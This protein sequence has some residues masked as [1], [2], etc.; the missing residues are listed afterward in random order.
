LVVFSGIGERRPAKVFFCASRSYSAQ[1]QA[2]VIKYAPHFPQLES[3]MPFRASSLFVCLSLSILLSACSHWPSQEHREVTLDQIDA[4]MEKH[5]PVINLSCP[6]P[7]TDDRTVAYREESLR[8]LGGISSQLAASK[9]AS[10]PPVVRT[11]VSRECATPAASGSSKNELDGRTIIGETEWIYLAPPGHHYKAR[12]DSGAA[13]SSLSAR[14]ITEFERNGK[15][16][17]R[18][19]LQ[20]DDEVTTPLQVE[21]KVVRYIRIRQA[22]ADGLERRPVIRL[23]VNLGD[24]LQQDAEFSLTDRSDM[25]YPIL[26]GRGFLRDVTLIDVGKQFLHPKYR[27]EQTEEPSQ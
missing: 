14:D 17:I 20:H 11:I 13:V 10:T 3:V 7:V 16:W 18:F 9:P 22:S 24:N 6:E 25:T 21:A 12:V 27:P 1:F 8:L 5:K 2:A 19:M 15:P 26:L 23:R 4:L